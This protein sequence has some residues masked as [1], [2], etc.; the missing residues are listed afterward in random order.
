MNSKLEEFKR[1]GKVD[2]VNLYIGGS[3]KE[4]PCLCVKNLLNNKKYKLIKL[5]HESYYNTN[6]DTEEFATEF[7]SV[8]TKLLDGCI[9]LEVQY[10]SVDEIYEQ[11]IEILIN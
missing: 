3:R 5:F 8:M 1:F 4:L 10:L 9:M 11:I 2:N 6:Q 7:F